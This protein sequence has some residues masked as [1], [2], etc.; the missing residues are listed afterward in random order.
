[1]QVEREEAHGWRAGQERVICMLRPRK[2]MIMGRYGAQ[3][4]ARAKLFSLKRGRVRGAHLLDVEVIFE[5]ASKLQ[6]NA[7]GGIRM[8][9]DAK[10]EQ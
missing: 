6:G 1:M 3:E 7:R 10:G 9:T 5:A 4:G 2:F 8:T